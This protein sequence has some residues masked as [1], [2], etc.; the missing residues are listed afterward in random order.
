MNT[1]KIVTGVAVCL[2]AATA[3]ANLKIVTT[4]ADLASI[5]KAVGGNHVNVSHLVVG[6]RDPHN[7]EA[8]PSYMSRVS[9]AD[10]FIAV[11]LELEVGYEQPI[12]EGSRNS[13]VR[14]G[15]PGHVYASRWAYILEK[16]TGPVNRSMGDVHPYGNPHLWLDP[17][18]G[19]SIAIG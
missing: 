1:L 6:A 4:T 16:P 14:V 3:P 19:R 13:K 2:L 8:K 17:Y 12:L 7:M 11:G 18:N 9:S 15:A 10:M 5:A